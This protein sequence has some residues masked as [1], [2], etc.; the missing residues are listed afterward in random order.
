MV[1]M[2]NTTFECLKCGECCRHLKQ[3]VL[4]SDLDRG[5]GVCRY[6]CGD[7]CSIYYERPI[8]CRIDDG[9]ELFKDKYTLEEYYEENYKVCRSFINESQNQK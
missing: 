5:D 8:K 3:S 4:Y 7:L 9:Y 1:G 6:L 2:S